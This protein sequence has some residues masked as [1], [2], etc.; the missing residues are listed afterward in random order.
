MRRPVGKEEIS[1]SEVLDVGYA[2][3]ECD[4]GVELNKEVGWR[5]GGNCAEVLGGSEAG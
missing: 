3:A 2:D 5:R 4:D 1:E